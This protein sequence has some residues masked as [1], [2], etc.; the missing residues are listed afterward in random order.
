MD[1]S[2]TMDDR[3][4]ILK[5]LMPT[6]VP[7]DA[8]KYPFPVFSDKCLDFVCAVD[9]LK[10]NIQ[11]I[12]THPS[13]QFDFLKMVTAVDY[14][15][16]D[17]PDEK[18]YELIYLFYS[19]LFDVNLVLRVFLPNQED[20]VVPTIKHI[21]KSSDWQEREIYDMF[22]IHFDRTDCKRIFMWDGFKGWP[23]RKDFKHIPD[24]FDD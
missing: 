16:I 24:R 22:G 20:I 19:Y 12:R 17:L 11:S 8:E 5:E 2:I 3:T 10:Q 7:F 4:K 15:G 9:E 23:L 6:V 21:W 14:L 18:R 13:L 1:S